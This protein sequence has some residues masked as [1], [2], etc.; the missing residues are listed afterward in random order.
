[1]QFRQQYG[2]GANI[3]RAMG[4]LLI[5]L[6]LAEWIGAEAEVSC[7]QVRTWQSEGRRLLRRSKL[8]LLRRW[9]KLLGVELRGGRWHWSSLTR[10]TGRG[11]LAHWGSL[12]GGRGG[13]SEHRGGLGRCLRCGSSCILGGSRSRGRWGSGCL[14][15]SGTRTG[16][17]GEWVV[18]GDR[19]EGGTAEPG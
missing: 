19:T 15:R 17:S 3:H 6:E 13:R 4:N 14:L 12:G 7:S 16:G 2:T 5:G 11:S 9:C 8:R 18:E 1:M 10:A